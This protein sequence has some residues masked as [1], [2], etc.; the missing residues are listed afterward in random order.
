MRRKKVENSYV[1]NKMKVFGNALTERS[2]AKIECEINQL[3]EKNQKMSEDGPV[4]TAGDNINKMKKYMVCH[5]ILENL[6]LLMVENTQHIA[7]KRQSPHIYNKI[8]EEMVSV[9]IDEDNMHE[10]ENKINEELR[11]RERQNFNFSRAKLFD[12]RKRRKPFYLLKEQ[13]K[14]ELAEQIDKTL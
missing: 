3:L 11:Q 6:F 4:D 2:K 1:R 5:K 12:L 7:L 10:I 13:K 9:M 8:K 14:D